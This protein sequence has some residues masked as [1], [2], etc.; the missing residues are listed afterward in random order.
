MADVVVKFIFVFVS[1]VAVVSICFHMS[2]EFSFG[3]ESCH[4]GFL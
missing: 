2:K 1:V 3:C 4:L